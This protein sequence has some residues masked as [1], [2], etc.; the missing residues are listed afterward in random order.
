MALREEGIETLK[1]VIMASEQRRG[2]LDDTRGIDSAQAYDKEGT[3]RPINILHFKK[4][5]IR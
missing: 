2:S 5:A 3:D 4:T 1:E